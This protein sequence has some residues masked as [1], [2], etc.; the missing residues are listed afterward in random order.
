MAHGGKRNGFGEQPKLDMTPMIDV[1]FQL[2]IFFVVALKQEDI[3]AKLTAARPQGG[4]VVER[5]VEA[6]NITVGPRGFELNG[7]PVGMA[8]LEERIGRFS[9]FSKS[10]SIVIRCKSDSPHALL[11]QALDICSKH[12]MTHLSIFS[13]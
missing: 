13:M 11:I 1:V 5:P 7:V 12:K 8:T 3:M 6:I 10:A 2:L 4:L 9:L